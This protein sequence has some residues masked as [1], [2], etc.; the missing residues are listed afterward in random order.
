MQ[1][2]NLTVELS[3]FIA[4]RTQDTMKGYDKDIFPYQLPESPDLAICVSEY[5][6]TQ[7][8]DFDT[9]NY[10]SVQI[11]VRGMSVNKCYELS[12]SILVEFQKDGGYI[13]LPSQR[14]RVE[15]ITS[16]RDAY[17]DKNKRHNFVTNLRIGYNYIK[18]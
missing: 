15:I 8:L 3:K 16:P 4:E 2:N 13:D 11:N 9:Y 7:M 17:I 18:N 6:S 12:H 14:C 10:R 1:L 5:N